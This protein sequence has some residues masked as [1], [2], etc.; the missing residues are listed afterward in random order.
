MDRSAQL[1]DKAC[2][3]FKVCSILPYFRHFYAEIRLKALLGSTDARLI[4]QQPITKTTR[5]YSTWPKQL[6]LPP[7]QQIR[8]CLHGLNGSAQVSVYP[9]LSDSAGKASF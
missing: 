5:L 7:R 3:V 6:I 8:L 1:C 4:K 2:M 9:D